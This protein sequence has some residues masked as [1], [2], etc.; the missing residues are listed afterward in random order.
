MGEMGRG[1][2]KAIKKMKM[3]WEKVREIVGG[4]MKVMGEL[5]KVARW[6]LRMDK[7]AGDLHSARRDLSVRLLAVKY[8]QKVRLLQP[9][10][11]DNPQVR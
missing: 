10:G 2:V 1:R 4:K 6:G 9:V 11:R 7:M 5:L 3:E 8:Q